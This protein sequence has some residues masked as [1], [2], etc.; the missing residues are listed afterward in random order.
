MKKPWVKW[1]IGVPIALVVLVTAG[2]WTYINVIRDEAPERLSLDDAG[3]T[4]PSTTTA[5][6]GTTETTGTAA[7]PASGGAEGVWKVAA[8]SQAGYRVNEVLFGQNATA[9]GR[10]EDV[11]GQIEIDGTS[12]TSG[13]FTVDMTTIESD[14]SRRDGQFRGRIMDVEN[15]PTSTVELTAPITLGT[16]PAD[17]EEV[18]V[19]AT[20]NLTLRGTTK[21]VTIDLAAQR[22]GASI[23]VAGT[24]PIVFEE[25]GIPNPSGGPASTEDNGELEFLLV[26]TA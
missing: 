14:E 15:F 24:I 13:S 5:A 25:W 3:T 10:T 8:G 6:S 11:T 12:V 19:K 17:G 20:G 2:T 7:A 1:A 26:L 4:A 9:V 22:S 21:K 16:L 18:T 23:T